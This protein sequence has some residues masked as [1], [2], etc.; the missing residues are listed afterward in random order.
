MS[1]GR[2]SV[3]DKGG[4]KYTKGNDYSERGFSLTKLCYNYHI[5]TKPNYNYHIYSKAG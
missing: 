1:S 2:R 5:I 4:T 3:S